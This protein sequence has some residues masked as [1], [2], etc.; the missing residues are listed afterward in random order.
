MRFKNRERLLQTDLNTH[1]LGTVQQMLRLRR[2]L[3]SRLIHSSTFRTYPPIAMLLEKAVSRK[4]GILD[5]V[6]NHLFHFGIRELV[7]LHGANKLLCQVAAIDPLVIGIEAHRN[8]GFAVEVE[9]V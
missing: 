5:A 1:L 4:K 6:A 9:G 3:P 2:R 7:G 8:P